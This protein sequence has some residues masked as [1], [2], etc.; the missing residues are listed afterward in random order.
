MSWIG[1]F[2]Q[3]LALVTALLLAPLLTGWVNQCRAWLQ[4]KSAPGLLQPYRTLHKL[5]NKESVMAEHAS[6]LYRT[7]PY[8]IFSCMALA[9][10]IVPTLSTDLPLS[11]AA[12]AIALVG[13]FALARVFIS[14][15]AM[16]VG[17]AFGS[18]GARREMLVG[19]LAEPALLM[20]LFCASM[21]TRS[22]SLTTMVETLAHREL[23]I[24]PSLLLAGVAFTLVSLAE[25]ARVPVDN[26]DTHLELTMIHEAMI[27]EY[28]ARHLA[29]LEWAASLKL[30]AYSCIGLA[31]FF[32]WGVADANSPMVLLLALPFLM[33]KLAVGG[34][35]LALIETLSAKMRI[36]RVPEFL[37]TAFLVAVIGLLVNVL[38]GVG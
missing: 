23:A 8:L 16:D 27:L 6:P 18:L 37:G 36:F 14:L 13:L 2:S 10:A 24:Y 35:V 15:A 11:P 1:V 9:C 20:V 34:V 7:A 33:V 31:L 5:F 22:T 26:P 25:N 3:L 28:S 19:F 38:L 29:L 17:T 32:P 21:I 30:F 4:N 12:D